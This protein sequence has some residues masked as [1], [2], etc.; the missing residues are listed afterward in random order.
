MTPRV[1]TLDLSSLHLSSGEAR[2]LDVS[3]LL[4]PLELAGELYP[5]G[6]R[7]IEARLDISRTVSSGYALRLRFEAGVEGPCMRC[8]EA[9]A[10]TFAV[11]AREISQPDDSRGRREGAGE[12]L[13]SPYVEQSVL[14]LRG[15]ARD[16]L[17]LVL[18]P[19]LLCT[20]DCAGLCAIC[21]ENLNTAGPEHH[22]DP[23]PD[24]RWAKLSELRFD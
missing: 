13:E 4:D 3:F 17:A 16:S 19:A 12:E 6:P 22:H 1:D 9:A 14:D 18:P 7:P 24:P 15:W 10:P 8:L 2:R 21:G 23:E 11:D 5:V 20:P